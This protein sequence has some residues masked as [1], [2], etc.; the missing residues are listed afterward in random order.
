MNIGLNISIHFI[1]FTEVKF[2]VRSLFLLNRLF[3]MRFDSRIDNYGQLCLVCSRLH[4]GQLLHHLHAI[5]SEQQIDR[6][7]RGGYRKSVFNLSG[8]CINSLPSA[9]CPT[10]TDSPSP[11][12]HA[13]PPPLPT[14]CLRA[15][16]CS[17][18]QLHTSRTQE[19]LEKSSNQ[20]MSQ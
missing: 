1:H 9:V 7:L 18:V 5:N 6:F 17:L 13:L 3:L 11:T 10:S 2:Y 4:P 14:A 12:Q 8:L 16:D 19:C 20:P 15:C